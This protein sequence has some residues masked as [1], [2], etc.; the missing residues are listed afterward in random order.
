VNPNRRSGVARSRRWP[1][2]TA[3]V[4]LLLTCTAAPAAAT[5]ANALTTT[6]SIDGRPLSDVSS[7][8]PLTL[9]RSDQTRVAVNFHNG[10]SKDL[11]IRSVRLEGRVIGMAFFSYATR[12]DIVLP[13]GASTDRRFD[14]DVEDLTTQANGLIPARLD[15]FG[16]KRKLLDRMPFTTDVRGSM[17]SIYGIFGL[18]IA[19]ITAVLLVTLLV[20]IWRQRL[21]RN[22]W[23]RAIWFLPVGVGLGLVLTFT[24]SAARLLAPG[25]QWWLP[26]VLV[27]AL[28]SFVLGYFLPIG[29]QAD[30]GEPPPTGDQQVPPL[31]VEPDAG[32]S[33]GQPGS[34]PGAV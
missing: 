27:C 14:V 22:R 3:L 20:A 5:P 9:G 1:L 33:I 25:P 7:N 24:L 2:A 13:P 8:R 19:G 6:A 30:P 18:I 17:A 29:A 10:G 32:I 11:Q 31:A 4:V 34:T 23:Q 21:P 28:G 16:P 15:V 26:L 12:L